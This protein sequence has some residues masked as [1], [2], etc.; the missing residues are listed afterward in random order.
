MRR[1]LGRQSAVRSRAGGGAESWQ[2]L[3][4]MSQEKSIEIGVAGGALHRSLP[5]HRQC[6]T[7]CGVS[8]TPGRRHVAQPATDEG[9]PEAVASSG[10]IELLDVESGLG[11]ARRGVEVASAFRAPLVNDCLDA[12]GE[13]LLDGGL[14][15]LRVGEEI[16]FDAARQEHIAASKQGFTS[17]SKAGQVQNLWTKI[18]VE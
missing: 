3:S 10:R 4:G 15:F 12:V 6:S 17:F 1:R 13:N 2:G 9:G 14:L 16:E 11:E 7:R 18:G 8:Q 5:R